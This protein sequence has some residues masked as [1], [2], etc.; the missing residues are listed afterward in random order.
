MILG[1][2]NLCDGCLG[3][4]K[5][6]CQLEATFFHIVVATHGSGEEEMQHETGSAQQHSNPS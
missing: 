6:G 3:R 2:G 5:E 1:M 4:G